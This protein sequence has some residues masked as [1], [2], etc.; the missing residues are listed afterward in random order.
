MEDTYRVVQIVELDFSSMI[1][2]FKST[3]WTNEHISLGIY[4]EVFHICGW[5]INLTTHDIDTQWFLQAISGGTLP[6][7]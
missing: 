5:H 6:I 3:K 2:N 4:E 7:F 1:S